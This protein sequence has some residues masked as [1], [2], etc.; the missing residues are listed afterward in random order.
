MDQPLYSLPQGTATTLSMAVD[1]TKALTENLRRM[2]ETMERFVQLVSAH[3]NNQD[4]FQRSRREGTSSS[5]GVFQ[6]LS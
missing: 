6:G 2:N 5:L 3:K 4:T 1:I